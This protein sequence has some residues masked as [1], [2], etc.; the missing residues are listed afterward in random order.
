MFFGQK[1]VDDNIDKVKTF[2]NYDK[3]NDFFVD[4]ARQKVDLTQVSKSLFQS[5]TSSIFSFFTKNFNIM[6]GKKVPK[7]NIN[8]KE[9]YYITRKS[10]TAVCS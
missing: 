5:P 1:L 8:P 6:G 4:V 7:L 9:V 3:R 10:R 2:F